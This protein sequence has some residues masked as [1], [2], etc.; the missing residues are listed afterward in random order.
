META[1]LERAQVTRDVTLAL[2]E[3]QHTRDVRTVLL[4]ALTPLREA[5]RLARI[6]LDAGTRDITALLVARARRIA[7]EERWLRAQADVHRADLRFGRAIGRI[8]WRQP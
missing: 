2:H 5:E 3:R 4:A 1:E 7:T 8:P 6:T